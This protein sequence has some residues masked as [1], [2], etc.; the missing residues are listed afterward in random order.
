MNKCPC[1]KHFNSN[2]KWII[3]VNVANILHA[4]VCLQWLI[5]DCL[6]LSAFKN[7]YSTSVC[8]VK[9]FVNISYFNDTVNK[10]TWPNF[11]FQ[12]IIKSDNVIIPEIKESNKRRWP[13]V[14]TL[15]LLLIS[16]AVL[17]ATLIYQLK[18]KGLYF[19]IF[20]LF[21]L[22]LQISTYIF[23]LLTTK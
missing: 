4:C 12:Y 21:F 8:H 19:N 22:I 10:Q 14:L 13:M 16:A 3:N 23:S 18:L 7:I 20:F 17:T 1:N 2:L 9:G 5:K 6:I 15:G 11:F